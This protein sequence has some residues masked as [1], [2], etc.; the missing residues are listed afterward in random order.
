[1]TVLPILRLPGNRPIAPRQSPFSR[2]FWDALAVGRFETTFCLDCGLGA[3]PPRFFC[4]HCW[5]QAIQWRAL[6][7]RGRLYSKTRVHAAATAFADDAPYD[8]ALVDLEEGL[9]VAMRL[10]D[11]AALELDSAVRLAV[12][13][14]EDGPLFCAQPDV[15]KLPERP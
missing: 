8:L 13:A 3:F 6:S 14:Y 5:S 9:R 10:M 7:G 2:R 15:S 12:L 4:P 11:G 1:V